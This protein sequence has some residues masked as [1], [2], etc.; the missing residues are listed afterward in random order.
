MTGTDERLAALH[1]LVE[2]LDIRG[3]C[4][5]QERELLYRLA[6]DSPGDGMIVEIGCYQGLSTIYLAAGSAAAGRAQVVA[7]DAH[8]LGSTAAL[9]E[10]LRR[11]ALADRVRPIAATSRQAAD[12]WDGQPIRLLFLDGDHQYESVQEDF[13]LWA[14]WLVPGGI[15]AFHDAIEP[16]WPGVAQC[17]DE[18]LA[19]GGWAPVGAAGSIV[20]ARK[21]AAASPDRSDAQL[22]GEG[23]CARLRDQEAI[24]RQQVA[25]IAHVEAA[26]QE[27][28][29]HIS[30]LEAELVELRRQHQAGERGRSGARAFR[31][32]R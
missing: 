16:N 18:Q 8:Y 29:A 6:R 26:W 10:N 13:A 23:V 30:R 1:R 24:L 5:P 21:L 11:A 17:L 3:W 32:R 2:E 12:D 7:I 25:H 22:F 15:I 28:N 14:R 4:K 9:R 19:G 27:K 20:C 31:R